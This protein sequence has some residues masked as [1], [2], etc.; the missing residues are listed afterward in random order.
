MVVSICIFGHAY[1]EECFYG[2]VKYKSAIGYKSFVIDPL[3]GL[4]KIF[5]FGIVGYVIEWESLVIPFFSR[6]FYRFDHLFVFPGGL[7]TDLER[8][9]VRPDP[10]PV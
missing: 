4:D 7:F 8:L 6:G 5:Y 3:L 10:E 9:P 1:Q 2:M